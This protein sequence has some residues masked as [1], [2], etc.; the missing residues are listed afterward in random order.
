[1]RA[2]DAQD[3][4]VEVARYPGSHHIVHDSDTGEWVVYAEPDEDELEREH[5]PEAGETDLN[6]MHHDSHRAMDGPPRTL[7]ALNAFN[8]IH[9]AK[10]RAREQ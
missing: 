10:K 4:K 6:D 9:Y 2:S 5:E 8:A 7:A 3:D 1:M